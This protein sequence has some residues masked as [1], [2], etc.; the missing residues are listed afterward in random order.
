MRIRPIFWGILAFACAA[1]LIFASTIHI[2]APA[3]MQVHVDQATP[4]SVGFTTIELHLSD[5]QGLP[6]EEAQ[7]TPSARMTN[8]DMTT[9]AILVKTRGQ[10]NYSVQ[11]QLYMAGPWEIDILAHADGFDALQQSLLVQVQ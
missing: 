11:F 2:H 6:I 9:R 3:I 10:G 5:T 1:V 7:V 4:A 8:M